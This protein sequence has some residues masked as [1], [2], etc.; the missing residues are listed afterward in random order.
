MSKGFLTI[1]QAA[2]YTGLSQS[3]LRRYINQGKLRKAT[4]SHRVLI[5]IEDIDQTSRIV[6]EKE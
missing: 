4:Y 5:P 6:E 2:E 3:T 1:Q